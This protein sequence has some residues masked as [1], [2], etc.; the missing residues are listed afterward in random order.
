MACAE[1]STIL[2]PSTS[3][4]PTGE[5]IVDGNQCYVAGRIAGRE[6]AQAPYPGG[7]PDIARP[8]DDIE[9]S[10]IDFGNR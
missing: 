3:G 2:T 8:Y 10:P 6:P 4:S 5:V 1:S 7:R 9:Y